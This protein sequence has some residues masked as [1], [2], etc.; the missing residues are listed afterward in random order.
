MN[1]TLSPTFHLTLVSPGSPAVVVETQDTSVTLSG[2]EPGVLH[3]VEIIVKACGKEG[4][5]AHLKV[6]TGEW[7]QEHVSSFV[8]RN[9]RMKRFLGS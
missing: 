8:L 3:L 5:S 1:L 4:V 2:L 9:E 6:R 7:L